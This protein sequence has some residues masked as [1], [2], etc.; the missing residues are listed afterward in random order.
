ML[1]HRTFTPGDSPEGIANS[2]RKNTGIRSIESLSHG[3]NF[4]P[5]SFALSTIAPNKMS[6]I[7]SQQ[8]AERKTV[9]TTTAAIPHL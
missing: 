4:P 8:R 6:L 2:R 1:S 5:F 3:K 7:A 9:P